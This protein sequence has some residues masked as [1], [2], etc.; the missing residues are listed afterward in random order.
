[1]SPDPDPHTKLAFSFPEDQES[2]RKDIERDFGVLD[3]KFLALLYPITLHDHHSIYYLVLVSILMHN[4]MVETHLEV[5][6]VE[7]V[8]MYNTL[9]ATATECGNM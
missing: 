5:D 8:K 7:C 2:H 6:K 9:S 4:M 3:F 1:M